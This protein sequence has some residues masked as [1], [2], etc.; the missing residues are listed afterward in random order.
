MRNLKEV[1]VYKAW[2]EGFPTDSG[3][4]SLDTRTFGRTPKIRNKLARATQQLC[5]DQLGLDKR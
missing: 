1:E 5:W 4:N 3:Q 2:E